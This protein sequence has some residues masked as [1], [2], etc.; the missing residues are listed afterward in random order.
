MIKRIHITPS[1]ATELLELY[2]AGES[3]LEQEEKLQDYFVLGNPAP[4]HKQLAPLFIYLAQEKE[5]VAQ[6]P[7]TEQVAQGQQGEIETIEH[8]V[9]AILERQTEKQPKSANYIHR[10]KRVRSFYIALAAVA[11]LV[12]FFSVSGIIFKT[13]DSSPQ[14]RLFIEGSQIHD[15]QLALNMALKKLQK[16]DK[17]LEKANTQTDK[18][19]QTIT[20]KKNSSIIK[21]LEIID[22]IKTGK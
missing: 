13:A 12:I 3:S 5:Q 15:Q 9:P 7:Q 2:F 21:H 20:L 18:A 11:V 6:A 19:L 14:Y 22:L 8:S 4:E 17:A 16:V 10:I 1:Q